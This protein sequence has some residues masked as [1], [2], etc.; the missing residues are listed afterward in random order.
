M[1]SAVQGWGFA[2]AQVG[3]AGADIDHLTVGCDPGH[4][5]VV[6]D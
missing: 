2:A 6:D 3:G 1:L 5:V 4:V